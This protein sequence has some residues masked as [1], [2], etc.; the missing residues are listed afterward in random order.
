MTELHILKTLQ[1]VVELYYQFS[2]FDINVY[3][4]S[5]ET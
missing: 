3:K 4:R 5:V 2:N 1:H